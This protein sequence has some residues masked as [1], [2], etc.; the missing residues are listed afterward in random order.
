[1]AIVPEAISAEREL[2]RGCQA[3]ELDALSSFYE[4]FFSSVYRF[5]Y[6]SVGSRE[7]AEDI[8]AE[9]F[10][11]AFRN[12]RRFRDQ[13]KPVAAWLFR[14]AR[15]EVADHYRRRRRRIVALPFVSEQIEHAGRYD[16]LETP[17]AVM[18]LVSALRN[19]P[20]AQR[21]AVLLR[22]VGGLST[23]QTA[24]AMARPEGTVRSLLHY[25]I[26]ALREAMQ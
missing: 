17:A 11:K 24:Q 18:D 1:M 8:T 16:P 20:E 2:M 23:R 3:G 7:D 22:L 6:G 4:R 14:I 26:K 21:E 9:V 10:I 5:A 25:G 15:H 19:L 12:I 13:A